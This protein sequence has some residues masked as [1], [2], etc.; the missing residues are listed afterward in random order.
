MYTTGLRKKYGHADHGRY[1]NYVNNNLCGFHGNYPTFCCP[2]VK[3]K[4]PKYQTVV[5]KKPS[6]TNQNNKKTVK[7]INQI[8]NDKEVDKPNVNR[9]N[10]TELQKLLPD[11]CSVSY[12]KRVIGGETEK[13]N[14][15]PWLALLEY[16]KCE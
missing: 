11:W 5:H 16:E 14:E 10:A 3:L 2:V 6:K 12:G 1:Q 9:P 15:T 7:K 4:K 8:G 13:L